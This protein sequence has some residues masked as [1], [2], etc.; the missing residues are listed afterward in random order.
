MRK[1]VVNRCYGGFS[2]S[3]MAYRVLHDSGHPVAKEA[4]CERSDG[5]G[6]YHVH[7]IERDDPALV[8]LVEKYGE[9][10]GGRHAELKIVEIPE[11]VEWEIEEYD[12]HEWV[13]E[14]HRTW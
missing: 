10:A 1:I 7:D 5:W 11:D 4:P 3:P 9:Q 13:S 2:L 8:S 14:K 12:G 6:S